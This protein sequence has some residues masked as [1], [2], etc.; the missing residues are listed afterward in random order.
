MKLV[1]ILAREL[2]E[3]PEGSS[4][5]WQEVDGY[6]SF[7]GAP[8]ARFYPRAI[9]EKNEVGIVFISEWKDE[10][11][12][13]GS[14]GDIMQYRLHKPVEP[15]AEPVFNALALRDLIR[16]ID[17]TI[18]A[19]EEERVMLVQILEAEGLQLFQGKARA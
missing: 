2:K 1:E 5:A 10:R 12:R 18:E 16:E 17:V 6:V 7:C 9:R 19:F 8:E 15:V 3:W 4:Y 13:I 11:A 14:F